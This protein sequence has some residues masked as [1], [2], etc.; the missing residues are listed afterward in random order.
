MR[1]H[2]KYHGEWA[3]IKLVARWWSRQCWP[4][5]SLPQIHRTANTMIWFHKAQSG[6]VLPIFWTAFQ[7]DHPAK[8]L[9]ISSWKLCVCVCVH[10]SI[11]A[12]KVAEQKQWRL[13]WNAFKHHSS[14]VQRSQWYTSTEL[15]LP[16]IS[17]WSSTTISVCS[18]AFHVYP[19]FLFLFLPF[20]DSTNPILVLLPHLHSVNY[21]LMMKARMVIGIM[22]NR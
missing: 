15:Q 1:K 3:S 13:M 12:E 18:Y 14:P 20:F 19:F 8:R 11:L 6:N 7:T 21:H 22:S 2:F 5:Q 9:C 4:R 16:C 17:I 10:A